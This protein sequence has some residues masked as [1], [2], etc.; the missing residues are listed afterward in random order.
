MTPKGLLALLTLTVLIS[1]SVQ[2]TSGALIQESVQIQVRERTA[3]PQNPLGRSNS[4][5]VPTLQR[6]NL[7]PLIISNRSR[8]VQQ[9]IRSHLVDRATGRFNVDLIRE[10][11]NEQR[12]VIRGGISD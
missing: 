12:A 9:Y 2:I 10:L 6:L 7:R 5:D 1:V 3:S 4:K 11:L 8:V